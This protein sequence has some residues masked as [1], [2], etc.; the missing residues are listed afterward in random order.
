MHNTYII[1]KLWPK[2]QLLPF[3]L[4]LNSIYINYIMYG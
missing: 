3:F 2:K 4:F 1:K